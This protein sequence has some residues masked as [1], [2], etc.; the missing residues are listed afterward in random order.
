MKN[1]AI[2]VYDLTVEYNIVVTDGITDFFKDKDDVHVIISTTSSPHNEVFQYDY[3]YWTAVELLKSKNID[4]AIVITNTYFNTI[5]L[6]ILSDSIKCLLPKPIISVSNPLAVEGNH[7]TSISCEQAYEQIIEHLI[8]KHNRTKIAF[9]N[10]ALTKSPESEEREKAFRLAMEKNGLKVNEDWI[11]DGDFTPKSAYDCFNKRLKK[12]DKPPFEAILC[13]NDYMAAGCVSIFS[14]LGISIP[15][16]V[17][18]F[19]FDNAEVAYSCQPTLSTIS[20]SVSMTGYKAA[21]LAYDILCGKKVP[22]KK[23]IQS[24]PIFRQS[25]GCIPKSMKDRGY[26]D[27]NGNFIEEASAKM[28]GLQLFNNS[29]NDMA[30]IFH[31][32][33]MTDTVPRLNEFFTIVVNNLNYIHLGM[34]A[35]CIYDEPIFLSSNDTFV[36]PEK[37]RLLMLIDN[38]AQIKENYYE[39][40]GIEFSPKEEILPGR[41]ENFASGNYYILPIFLQSENYGYLVCRFPTNKYPVYT[42]F[43]K[44]LVNSFVHSYVYSKKDAERASLAEKN[45]TLNFQSKTDELTKLFNRRGFYEYGQQLLDV[46]VADGQIGSVFFCDL[47]GLKGINDTY[48]HEIGDLAIKTEAKVLRA[49]FRDSDMVG[50]LSGDEF[51]IVAPGLPE[52]KV[53]VI[54]ERIKNLNEEFSQEANL[55]FILSISIGPIEFD[56]EHTDL[57]DLLKEADKELYKEKKIKHAERKN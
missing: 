12:G 1:I 24:F 13:A 41:L 35:M 21:E 46:A 29:I 54:R 17:C 37:A 44:I 14:E 6:E 33:T 56:S 39:T 7:Y 22:E 47:D 43:L 3:Q 25:C 32:L 38:D 11:Y 36:T 8:K 19:G 34:L 16:D 52:R 55:P 27:V 18:I 2:L 28:D 10:A 5:N 40:G 42:I 23:V 53:E 57:K 30:T 50:R 49:A 9:M 45:Q 51:G 31:V 15:E 4:A 20:Q 26:Y 48:G